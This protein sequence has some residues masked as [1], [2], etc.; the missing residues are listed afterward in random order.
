MIWSRASGAL[1]ETSSTRRRHLAVMRPVLFPSVIVVA[2]LGGTAAP[3]LADPA[4]PTNYESTVLSVQPA[5]NAVSFEII[6]GDAFISVTVTAGHELIVPGY[7]GEPYI[8]VAADGSVFVNQNS[9][10]LYL[11]EDRY[12]DAPIPDQFQDGADPEWGLVGDGGQYAWHDHRTHWMSV[13]LP[14]SVSVSEGATIFPWEFPVVVDGT[15]V[16]VSGELAWLPSRNPVPAL[17][18]GVLALAPFLLW[19][20]RRAAAWLASLAVGVSLVVVIAEWM[21]TPSVARNAPVHAM[22]PIAA[23]VAL[24][25]PAW[26]GEPPAGLLRVTSLGGWSLLLAW[27]VTAADRLWLPVLVSGIPPI[28][29]RAAVSFVLWATILGLAERLFPLRHFREA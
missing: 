12:G 19:S 22:L 27:T 5:T 9:R 28:I 24:S 15:E 18:A 23:L 7:F 2:L 26:I 21:N 25:A 29:E 1:D 10:A 11:N 8:R 6:G 16:T 14:P 3:A 4:E 17:M 13:D 20:R